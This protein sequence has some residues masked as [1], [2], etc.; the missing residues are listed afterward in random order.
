MDQTPAELP[1]IVRIGRQVIIELIDAEGQRE[2]LALDVVPD[3]AADFTEGFL[4]VSTP[5]AKAIMG[6]PAGSVIPYRMADIVEVHVLA[7]TPGERAPTADA[8]AAR[9][10]ATQEAVDRANLEDAVRLALTVNVKWGGYDPEPLEP[11]DD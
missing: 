1:E 6:L 4:G 10:A 8:A 11:A 9:N 2:Q 7:V 3:D 5:L